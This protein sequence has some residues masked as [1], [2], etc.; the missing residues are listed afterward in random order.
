[1]RADPVTLARWRAQG[2]AVH[3]HGQ[4]VYDGQPSVS[5]TFYALASAHGTRWAAVWLDA[6]AGRAGTLETADTFLDGT[7]F[8][9]LVRSTIA[10]QLGVKDSFYG[11]GGTTVEVDTAY[12]EPD[13]TQAPLS[14]PDE[15]WERVETTAADHAKR[16]ERLRYSARCRHCGNLTGSASRSCKRPACV[17]RTGRMGGQ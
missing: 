4:G 9:R 14:P 2:F 16:K 13:L 10:R 11:S 6:Q 1:M 8:G 12:A 3:E 5:V 7:A 17:Y 15:A